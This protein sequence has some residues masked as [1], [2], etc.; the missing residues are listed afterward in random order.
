MKH[1]FTLLLA[2]VF[3]TTIG[4]AQTELLLNGGFEDWTSDTEPTSWT[5]AENCEKESTEVHGGSFSVKHTGGTKDIQQIIS[6]IVPGANYK[7]TI[8]Y[9]IVENDG[10]DARIWS[11]WM[12]GSSYDSNTDKDKLQGP[13]NAYLPA[14][15]G[16]WT[17]YEV[18]LTA[19]DGADGFSFE[20]RTYSGA[21]TYW[22]D[23]SFEKEEVA[24]N[25]V[26]TPTFDP[27][28]GVAIPITYVK[29]ACETEGATILF[30]LDG[31]DP[32]APTLANP[33][34]NGTP[35]VKGS[36][37]SIPLNP[38]VTR[39]TVKAIAFKQGMDDSN[40]AA[41][42][43]QYPSLKPNIG[44]I[45]T[46]TPNDGEIYALQTEF[47][48]TMVQSFRNQI[49]IQDATG[50]I[51]IDDPS[52]VNKN[53]FEIGDKITGMGAKLTEYGGMLQLNL[54]NT[55]FSTQ[56]KGNAIDPKVITIN[57]LNSNFEMYESQLVMIKGVSFTAADGSA[58]FENGNVYEI[59]DGVDMGKFRTT[60]YGVDYIGTVIPSDKYNIV[61][62][63]NSRVENDE[64]VFF[65]SS[66]MQS[67][68]IVDRTAVN[69]LKPSLGKVYGAQ[70]QLLINVDIPTNVSIY[71]LSGKL[72]KQINNI[73][74][75][76]VLDVNSGLFL[77]QLTQAG[78]SET[79]KVFVK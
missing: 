77:V 22:D 38:L 68:F 39:H 54:V 44:A 24:A 7:L 57:D 11:K 3:F 15:G 4:L 58:T 12:S 16:E 79:I 8:W 47:L 42:E 60:F 6:D 40:I 2:F 63:M 76:Q 50:G 36:I 62:I 46:M 52:G 32:E 51:L 53:T 41:A 29:I 45:R 5:K 27:T 14:N 28:P 9:K 78:K 66:R 55:L 73:S 35:F 61:G 34:G 67:D 25:I 33:T 74:S 64:E 10:T 30:T 26:A 69:D 75:Q 43:Y 31:S 56:D 59:T 19:P 23:F 48:V 1:F 20:V 17:K 72:L 37:D 21:V 13:A 71:S 65:I 49:F 70:G 18:S